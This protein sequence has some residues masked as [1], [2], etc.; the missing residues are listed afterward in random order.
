MPRGPV[1][2]KY[3]GQIILICEVTRKR[4][5]PITPG[6]DLEIPCPYTLKGKPALMKRLIVVLVAKK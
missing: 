5:R 2:T 3:G 1:Y 4:K 6:K